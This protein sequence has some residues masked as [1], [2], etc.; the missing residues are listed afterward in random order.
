MKVSIDIITQHWSADGGEIVGTDTV[1]TTDQNIANQHL[2]RILIGF[3]EDGHSISPVPIDNTRTILRVN[4]VVTGTMN[5]T[6]HITKTG[7]LTT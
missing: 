3:L 4:D 2:G 5:H 6:I 7:K 1:H